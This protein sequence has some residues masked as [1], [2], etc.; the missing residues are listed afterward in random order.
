MKSLRLAALAPL[1]FIAACKPVVLAPAGDI[2]AQQRD[3]LVIST[4]LMLLI[5]IPVIA[6]V[7][8]FAWKYRESNKDAEYDPEFHH[9]TRLELVIW[10]APLM[11]IIALGALTWV[12]T[13]LLDPYRPLD[14]IAADKPIT[15]DYAPLQVQVVA[16]DWK[17]MFIY[18]EYGVATVNELAVPVDRPVEFTIT[19]TSVMNAF[20]IPAMAGMIYAM[21]AMETKLHGVLN[22][23]GTYEG[24][25]SHYSGHGFSHMRFSTYAMQPAD[26]DGW[27]EK[28]RT[29][30]SALDRTRYAEL[31]KPSEAVP[32]MYF[33]NVAPDLWHAI[34]NRCVDAN[35][36][37][38][39][40]MMAVD[41]VGGFGMAG[42]LNVTELTQKVFTRGPT[43]FGSQPVVVDAFCTVLDSQRVY[44]EEQVIVAAR[45]TSPLRGHGL[46]PGM[47]LTPTFTL[48][49]APQRAQAL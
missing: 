24:F 14:R 23:E 1:A 9:S 30:G 2:A 19:A 42:T 40:E 31:E 48:L 46:K 7:I 15:E 8:F 33:G 6:L 16:M 34:L 4:L 38:V 41:E 3:V 45:D 25:S 36:M 18:P 13:H 43:P 44:G 29:E 49:S 26:F 5:I 47:S 11:I 22:N 21:P 37:C 28:V 35:R 32:V 20:Y 39:D 17:W 10:A 12:G 27:V